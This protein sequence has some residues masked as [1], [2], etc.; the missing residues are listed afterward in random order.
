MTCSSTPS[1]LDGRSEKPRLCGSVF[2]TLV[3]LCHVSFGANAEDKNPDELIS[4]VYATWIGSGVY[5]VKGR[6]VAMLRLP[7]RY[8]L[9]DQEDERTGLRVLLPVTA[10]IHHFTGD[11]QTVGSLAF[12][13]GIE[14][15]I[16]IRENLRI[17]PFLQ[18]G[19]GKDLSGGDTAGI[20][21]VGNRTRYVIPWNRFEFSLGNTLGVLGHTVW[22]GGNSELVEM[23]E[24]GI[25]AL[26]PTDIKLGGEELDMSVFFYHSHFIFSRLDFPKEDGEDARVKNLYH[27]GLS[28][29]RKKPYKL[30]RFTLP[31]VGITYT[32]GDDNLTGIRFNTGFPF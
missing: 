16:P 1:T 18:A 32:F 14:Y 17:K 3:V 4:Y 6:S 7:F 13:P 20:Y 24:L 10:G 2:L 9:R 19:L 15:E 31:R 23:F 27:F 11:T 22:G 29:G 8:T 21:G 25:D 12:V 30:W 26:H 28:L 5:K